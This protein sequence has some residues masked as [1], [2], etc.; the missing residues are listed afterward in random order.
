LHILSEH[1]AK[2]GSTH[3]GIPICATKLVGFYRCSDLFHFD[4]SAQF[5]YPF[6]LA[7]CVFINMVK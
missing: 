5:M 1:V 7:W 2:T 4:S 6:W 3:D